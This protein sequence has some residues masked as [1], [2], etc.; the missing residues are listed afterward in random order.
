MC[1]ILLVEDH[2][3]MA[4]ALVSVLHK[5]GNFKVTVVAENAQDALERLPNLQVDLALV[6]VV[7]P[8]TSGIELVSMIHEK[9]P[10]LPCLMNSGRNSS[11]YVKRSLA[12]G[13]RGYVLKD[14][15][16]EVV[17]GIR[18]VLKGGTYL[19]KQIAEGEQQLLMFW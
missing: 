6:D 4:E 14:D 12:A 7:L 9:Y 5:K 17:K 11:Q 3:L 1:S 13:A 2:K 8:H 10:H 15:I 19:S 16:L 18:H